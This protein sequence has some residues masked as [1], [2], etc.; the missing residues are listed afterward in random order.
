MPKDI[1]DIIDTAVKIGLGASIA[2]VTTY[3]LSERNNKFE[4]AK[5]NNDQR[6]KILQ[7]IAEDFEHANHGTNKIAEIITIYMVKKD[8]QLKDIYNELGNCIRES[9]T[10]IEKVKAN[11]NLLSLNNIFEYTEE[12]FKVL[13]QLNSA[14]SQ[15][16]SGKTEITVSYINEL[17]HNIREIR[18]TFYPEISAAFI[19]SDA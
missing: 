12:Y 7:T 18:S 3:V 17:L 11:S 6:R 4:K 14:L 15:A 9:I 8:G 19:Q 13:N 16:A 1:F 10:D 5:I 2:G